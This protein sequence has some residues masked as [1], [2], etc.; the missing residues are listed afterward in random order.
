M[1][2]KITESQVRIKELESGLKVFV[3]DY[4]V[5]YRT[6]TESMVRK[7]EVLL[8]VEDR[9]KYLRV[10][11]FCF[12]GNIHWEHPTGLVM[13]CDNLILNLEETDW[14]KLLDSVEQALNT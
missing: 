12:D 2:N 9:R 14:I 6:I 13:L 7:A 10:L 4:K 8:Q 3:D 1:E 11:G 5:G